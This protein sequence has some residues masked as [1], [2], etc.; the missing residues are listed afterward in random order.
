[1]FI[2]ITL[3]YSYYFII[4]VEGELFPDFKK[5]KLYLRC[6]NVEEA[7]VTDFIEKGIAIFKDNTAGPQR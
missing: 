6:V 2:H 3:S 1:M 5:K 7:I 4:Q